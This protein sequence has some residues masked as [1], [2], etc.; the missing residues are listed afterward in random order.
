MIARLTLTLMFLWQLGGA[1][2]VS[3]ASAS[4]QVINQ[5]RL[6]YTTSPGMPPPNVDHGLRR[7]L[8]DQVSLPPAGATGWYEVQ[9]NLQA[10]PNE[11]WA[12]YFPEVAVNA[13]IFLND[14]L[15]GQGIRHGSHNPLLTTR[16]LYLKIPSGLLRTGINTFYIKLHPMQPI[17]VFLSRIHIG[18]APELRDAFELRTF[19]RV[20]IPAAVQAATLVVALCLIVLWMR[21]RREPHYLW[22]AA[23]TFFW[24]MHDIDLINGAAWQSRWT[25]GVGLIGFAICL[26]MF[27]H[28]YC[29]L[30]KPRLER[31]SFLIVALVLVFLTIPLGALW[32][33]SA[34][35]GLVAVAIYSSWVIWRYYR[36]SRVP[37][38]VP[39]VI[40]VTVIALLAVHEWLIVTGLIDIES[41]HLLYLGIPM[42]QLAIG[43][44]L[45][46]Q[47]AHTLRE[48]Q[49][50]NQ[51]LARRVRLRTREL[52][53]KHERLRVLER[54]QV[55]AEERARMV[56]DMHDGVGGQLVTALV[57]LE[58]GQYTHQEIAEFLHDTLDD[59]R[60][61]IESLDPLHD[62]LCAA[63]ASLRPRIEACLESQG[64]TLRWRLAE[65]PFNISL[66][67]QQALQVLRIVQEAVTNIVKHA[68]AQTVEIGGSIDTAGQDGGAIV[69]DIADDG[70]GIKQGAT[71]GRG[72]QTMASRA[73]DIGGTL[74][75]FST[76]KGTRIRLRIPWRMPS[77]LNS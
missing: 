11:A 65:L 34:W 21:R 10:A 54:A 58:S 67:P 50:L 32:H 45:I 53:E 25:I 39:V 75:I 43:I 52:G 46:Y 73:K 64:I 68:R 70:I 28:R 74:D 5:A 9:L 42:L 38:D 40:T 22:L 37:V 63:L 30:G 23:A 26:M 27:V 20:N 7:S 61:I 12:V 17:P 66:G 19:W 60:L 36:R 51:D 31:A 14:Q 76:D 47:Y 13:A 49:T 59:L 62:D 8:P 3:A 6:I 44:T 24:V 57:M 1:G 16:P 77:T 72:M 48:T 18:S 2:Q 4:H 55:L 69:I 29:G 35:F 41:N 71:S 33:L 15:L 56:R